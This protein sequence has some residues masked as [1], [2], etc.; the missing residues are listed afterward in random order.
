MSDLAFKFC[1]ICERA[2]QMWRIENILSE[3]KFVIAEKSLKEY[4]ILPMRE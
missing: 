2:K 3:L 1:N 4:Y